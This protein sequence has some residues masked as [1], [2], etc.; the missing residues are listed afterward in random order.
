MT[1]RS[2]D[3]GGRQTSSLL[4]LIGRTLDPYAAAG[5]I[6]IRGNDC[7]VGWRGVTYL[8]LLRYDLATNAA[9]CGSLSVGSGQLGMG[10]AAD[11]DQVRLVWRETGGPAP[12]PGWQGLA[13][14]LNG[15]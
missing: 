6:T 10:V 2:R 3:V 1:D 11:G 9:K 5:W 12:Q 14:G 8:S 4:T 13:A 15:V 7:D